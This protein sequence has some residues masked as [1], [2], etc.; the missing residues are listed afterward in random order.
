[1]EAPSRQLLANKRPWIARVIR[2]ATNQ[3]TYWYSPAQVVY[4]EPSWR[5]SVE[6]TSALFSDLSL[7]ES[8]P[9]PRSEEKKW[10]IIGSRAQRLILG[11]LRSG[12]VGSFNFS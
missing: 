2:S 3:G 7:L 4:P 10:P 12:I 11:I 5:N 9:T 6:T 8:N 1:M